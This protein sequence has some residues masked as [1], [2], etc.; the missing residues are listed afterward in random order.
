[1]VIV[2]NTVILFIYLRETHLSHTTTGEPRQQKK[3]SQKYRY[4]CKHTQTD[5]TKLVL[6]T[7]THIYPSQT[8][9][10]KTH[11][12]LTLTCILPMA[13]IATSGGRMTGFR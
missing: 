5:R 3:N 6:H 4:T 13:P 10:Y 8:G 11:L 9:I 2:G 1:M 7:N 12:G